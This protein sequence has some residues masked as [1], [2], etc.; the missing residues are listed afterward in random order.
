MRQDQ[1]DWKGP[2]GKL[3][4]FKGPDGDRPWTLK[5]WM[6]SINLAPDDDP[7]SY[8]PGYP[9]VFAYAK[10]EEEARKLAEKHLD[11][12]ETLGELRR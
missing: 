1:Q 10:S 5:T 2:D 3:R 6:F 9:V 7:E 8:A 4:T 11:D 12:G